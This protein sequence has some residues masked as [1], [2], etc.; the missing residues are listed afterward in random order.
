[1]TMSIK[2]D[3]GRH[4]KWFGICVVLLAV[5]TGLLGCG[6]SPAPAEYTLTISSTDGG[7]VTTPGE[8][9]F[10]YERGTVVHL[11]A[12]PDEGHQ[13]LYWTG[14]VGRMQVTAASLTIVMWQ[15]YSPVANF[16][17]MFAGGSGTPA[18][19]FQIANWRHLDNVRIYP[20]GW[21]VLINDLHRATPGYS[22]LAGPGANEGK[23][24]QPIGSEESGFIGR[25]D[26][27][28]YA[29]RDLFIDRPDEDAVGLFGTIGMGGVVE[30]VL[31]INA[32]VSGQHL[33][34]GLVG[35]NDGTVRDCYASGS[36]TGQSCVGALVGWNQQGMV[37]NCHSQGSVMGDWGVGGLVGTNDSAG[38]VS[39]SYASGNVTGESPIGGLVG[40]NMGDIDNS[41]SVCDVTSFGIAGGLVGLNEGT[42]WYTYSTGSVTDHEGAGGLVGF[43]GGGGEVF[44]SYWDVEASG[45]EDSEGGYGMTTEEMMDILI[46]IWEDWDITAVEPGEADDAYIWNIVDGQTYPFLSWQAI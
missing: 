42:V 45:I 12:K 9:S 7:T 25:L 26:G 34:G 32:V 33:V 46:Y 35:G 13:F 15:N 8:G 1:M 18:D 36:V 27:Q 20:D 4:M 14:N 16:A 43:Y 11:E 19:P 22:A 44:G 3:R 23:G 38:T 28:G 24:W 30:D 41:Y 2:L 31:I 39:S 10:T 6:P 40:Y 17:P 37:R 5:V 21:F 29:I